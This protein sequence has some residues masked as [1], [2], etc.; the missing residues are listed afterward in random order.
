MGDTSL[1]SFATKVLKGNRL[2]FADLRRLERDVLPDGVRSREE[3]EILISLD[4]TRTRR[5]RM[6][7]L[8][9]GR[10]FR[11]RAVAVTVVQ[12]VRIGTRSMALGI[13]FAGAAQ[14]RGGGSAGN[15]ARKISD[16]PAFCPNGRAGPRIGGRLTNAKRQ[17]ESAWCVGRGQA[18]SRFQRETCGWSSSRRLERKARRA[19]VYR[20]EPSPHLQFSLERS[21]VSP[22]DAPIRRFFV[23]PGPR[24]GARPLPLAG[25]ARV[26]VPA[27]ASMIVALTPPPPTPPRKGEESSAQNS[28]FGAAQRRPETMTVTASE[29]GTPAPMPDTSAS[30]GPGLAP[31]AR[32][33]MT[34]WGVAMMEGHMVAGWERR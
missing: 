25:R 28:L 34:M 10:P 17:K 32:R 31:T 18:L 16:G 22:M 33:G 20:V 7:A 29:P 11:I 5:C 15:P 12:R 3:A 8:P 27:P 6:A 30:M 13:A 19:A 1:H 21:Q 4:R 24:S 2:L 14:D 26:G 23:I 9:R